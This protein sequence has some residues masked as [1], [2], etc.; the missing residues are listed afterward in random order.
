MSLTFLILILFILAIV[1]FF[2]AF[3]E[4]IARF[5]AGNA[6]NHNNP[7]ASEK[8][9]LQPSPIPSP[10]LSGHKTTIVIDG[11]APSPEPSPSPHTASPAPNSTPSPHP[12]AKPKN[13]PK[14][15]DSPKPTKSPVINQEDLK[16]VVLYFAR[17]EDNGKIS[18]AKV[19]RSIRFNDS[20]LVSSIQ[21]LLKG[22]SSSE[23][24]NGI[25]T[26]IPPGTSLLSAWVTNSIAY[27]NFSENFQFNSLGA[28]GLRAQ[29]KQVV[30][31][32][33]EFPTVKAVQI[34]IDGKNQEYLGGDNVEIGKPITR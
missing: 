16:A 19:N 17:V 13:S 10:A 25:V 18:M 3:R 8:P 21:A 29:V 28:D 23:L 26:M 34:L 4:P 11:G 32:A 31:L 14:P 1:V 24:S 9:S 12:S 33:T 30:W 22:P 6:A 5:A 15:L 7:S 2:L 27:L 20:Y